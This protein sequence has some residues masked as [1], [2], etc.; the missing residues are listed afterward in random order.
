MPNPPFGQKTAPVVVNAGTSAS[1]WSAA[2]GCSL[3]ANSFTDEDGEA[4][5]C[6]KVTGNAANT[7]AFFDCTSF[8]STNIGKNGIEFDVYVVAPTWAQIT[9]SGVVMTMTF[10]DVGITNTMATTVQ[11]VPGRWNRV[12]LSKADFDSLIGSPTWDG[13]TFTRLRFKILGI[14]GYTAIAYIKNVS[15]AGYS[16]AQIAVMSDDIGI[17]WYSTAYP[18]MLA[19]NIKSTMAVITDAIGSGSFG[20]YARMSTAQILEMMD[21][22]H[23]PINHTKSHGASPFMTSYTQAQAYAEIN[24]AAEV[25]ESLGLSVNNS[26]RYYAAP[27]GEWSDAILA[28]CDEAGIVM[29]RG[30]IGDGGQTS[31]MMSDTILTNRIVPVAYVI[32][33]TPVATI[34]KWIDRTIAKGGNLILLFHHVVTTPAA[35]IEYSTANFKLVMDYLYQRSGM[36]DSVTIPEMYTRSKWS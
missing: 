33:T 16:R 35:A 25:M 5:T 30:T 19:R 22:G 4:I 20:G 28:A 21:D 13:T 2:S 15:W 23:V 6:I 9:S 3:A 26:A 24:G 32:N 34:Y 31:M 18:Y 1:A 17:S 27:Y 12:R 7:N 29:M 11:V 36:F 10:C 14:S 8:N